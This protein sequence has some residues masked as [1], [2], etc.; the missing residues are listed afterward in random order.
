[1]EPRVQYVTTS[2][3]GSTATHSFGWIVPFDAARALVKMGIF[4]D[5][6]P[7]SAR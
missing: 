2:D 7:V 6:S 1:M 4:P 3:G 5:V